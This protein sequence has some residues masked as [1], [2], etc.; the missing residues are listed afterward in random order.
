MY[1]EDIKLSSST[2][3]RQRSKTVGCSVMDTA[4]SMVSGSITCT[5]QRENDATLTGKMMKVMK[6]TRYAF[7]ITDNPTLYSNENRSKTKRMKG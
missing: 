2:S 3:A 4:G 7:L 6:A 1:S 5:S